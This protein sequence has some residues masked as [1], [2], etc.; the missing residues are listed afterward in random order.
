MIDVPQRPLYPGVAPT[1][2]L[3]G[4][5]D[6]EF[7]DLAHDTGAARSV[8]RIRPLGSDEPPVPCQNCLGRH[9]RRDLPE[10]LLAQRL[11]LRRETPALVIG[12]SEAP[13]ARLELFLEDAVLLDQIGDHAGL[14][15]VGPRREG[16]QE[17]L[18][19]D[20]LDH[21]GRVSNGWKLVTLHQV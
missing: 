15:A 12:E 20:G 7:S 19:L 10:R 8:V 3:L 13:P 18:K 16:R 14:L 2:T 11:A 5:A 4:H 17:E 9:D 1:R 21:P 6:H